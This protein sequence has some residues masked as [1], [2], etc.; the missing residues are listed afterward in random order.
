MTSR[1]AVIAA[2]DALESASLPYMV[3]G[4]LSSSL[5]GIPRSTRDAD[6]VIQLGDRPIQELVDGM[7]PK[8]KLD[9][10]LSFETVTCTSRYIVNTEKGLFRIEL[11]LLSDD[12][13]DQERFSRRRQ[14]QVL[15][16]TTIVPTPEDVIVTKIRWS[17]Q[18]Q[19]S[20]DTDDARNVMAVQGGN[21]DWDY[22]H[23]WCDE[24]GTR[25]L[26]DDI[27]KS[28]PEI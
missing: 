14:S 27:R 12:P 7:G 24:H 15:G 25:Q 3:V 5:Y 17:K 11:F 1:Q 22:I 21:L 19:R 4:S 28:I 20:K 16:R 26:L 8:F 23:R 18:G 6:F 2:I 10:Q 13:H 9:P